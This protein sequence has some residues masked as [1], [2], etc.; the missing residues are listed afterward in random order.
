VNNNGRN[1]C[2]DCRLND[3]DSCYESDCDCNL[4]DHKLPRGPWP[5]ERID[6]D[7][8]LIK[9]NTTTETP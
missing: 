1:I 2:E 6:G 9:K 4:A 7:T 8:V 3:C 5:D